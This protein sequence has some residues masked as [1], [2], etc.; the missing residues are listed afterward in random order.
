MLFMK[1]VKFKV[2]IG[3]H[4]FYKDEIFYQ[5]ALFINVEFSGGGEY[6]L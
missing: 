1:I 6:L 3:K 4:K 2:L 5:K